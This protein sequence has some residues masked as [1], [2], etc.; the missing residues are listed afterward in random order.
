MQIKWTK[1]A[2]QN[3]E[4]ILAHIATDNASASQR[5]MLNTLEQVTRLKDYPMLGRSGLVPSTRELVIHENYV[6]YYR[7]NNKQIEILRVLHVRQK[8]P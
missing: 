3:L 4:K 1:R 8:F 7:I 5:F 6:I 2:A